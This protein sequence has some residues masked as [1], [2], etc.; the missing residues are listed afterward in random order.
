LKGKGD[1]KLNLFTLSAIAHAIETTRT[2]RQLTLVNTGFFFWHK[3]APLRRETLLDS[4]II[5]EITQG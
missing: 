2:I 3:K 1:K 5:E 4:L